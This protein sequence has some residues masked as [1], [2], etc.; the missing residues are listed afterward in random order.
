MHVDLRVV[1]SALFACLFPVAAQ[2]QQSLPFP[3][4]PS[5]GT[6]GPTIAQ[7]VYEPTKHV[8]H[9]PAGA[10]NVVIIMLDDVGPAL[11]DTFGGPV[12]TPTLS[13]IAASGISYNRFHNAAMCSPTRAALLT[14]RN[15]HRVGFGQIAE[16]ANDWDG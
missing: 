6:A 14:G 3:A 15:H 8:N 7:S 13:R 1:A 2:A 5:A 4:P 11:P 9:L 10:H 16:L 12:H